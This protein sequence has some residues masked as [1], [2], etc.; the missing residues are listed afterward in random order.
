VVQGDKNDVK[1]KYESYGLEFQ[2][3]DQEKQWMKR[4]MIRSVNNITKI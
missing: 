2:I 1:T 4:S 3:E